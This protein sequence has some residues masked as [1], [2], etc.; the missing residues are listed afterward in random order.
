MSRPKSGYYIDGEQVPGVTTVISRF[1]ESGALMHWAWCQGKE[2]KDFRETKQAAADAGTVAHDMV[3][4][5]IYGQRFSEDGIDPSILSAAR[6][7]YEAYKE[8]KAQTNLEIVETET[9]LVSRVHRFGGTPDAMAIRGKL[10]LMDWKTSNGVYADYLL[11]LAAY[12]ILWEENYPE[13]PIEGGFH[14]LR[15]SKPKSQSDPTAFDHRYWSHLDIAKE[16]FLYLLSAYRLDKRV[17]GL[18]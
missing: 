9:P 14:L 1:K 6:G 11:Q 8:W 16:Q 2:G 10:S 13:R 5:D 18:L 12:Q 3:E 17:K 4:H 15:F 7:A